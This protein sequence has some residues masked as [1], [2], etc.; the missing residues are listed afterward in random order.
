MLRRDSKPLCKICKNVYLINKS[1]KS[2][3]L[4]NVIIEYI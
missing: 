3:N 2:H 1:V 4:I